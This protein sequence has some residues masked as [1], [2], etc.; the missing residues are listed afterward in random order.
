MRK[1]VAEERS[2]T[3]YLSVAITTMNA[4]EMSTTGAN[5]KA[6]SSS[7]FDVYFSIAV[8]VIALVGIAGNALVLYALFASKQHN[9]LILVVN[10]NALDLFSSFALFVTYL[11]NLCNINHS[12]T[13]GYW[14]CVLI[15]SE[16]LIWGGTNGSI[17]K[18]TVPLS[19]LPPLP[20]TAI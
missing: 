12:G 4:D 3:S 18:L 16:N 2:A 5:N 1:E 6:S 20:L 17:I 15:S 14:L 10:Q 11:L 7:N 9:K 13:L 19:I 8:V